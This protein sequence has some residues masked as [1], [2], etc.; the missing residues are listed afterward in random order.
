[1]KG[2]RRKEPHIVDPLTHPRR[3]VCLRVAARYLGVD[4]RTLRARVESGAIEARRDGKVY[5]IE[6]DDL[7][8]YNERR[9]QV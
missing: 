9:A 3:S 7:V 1:M 2:G 5:R 4:E 8:R 6:V